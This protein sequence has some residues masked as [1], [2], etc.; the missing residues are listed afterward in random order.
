VSASQRLW[1]LS[2]REL[3]A[4]MYPHCHTA[5]VAAWLGRSVRSVYQAAE[6]RGIRKDAEYLASDTACRIQRG[7]T[8][9][10]MIPHRF[11]RGQ[12]PWNRG[13]RGVNG[14]SATRF[15]K[16]SMP[17][18]WRPV[19]SVRIERDGPIVKVSDTRKKSDW[20]PLRD[21]AWEAANGPIPAGQIVTFKPGQHTNEP[22]QITADRL[23]L[24]DRSELMRRNGVYALYGPEI[25]RLHQLRGA[26]TRQIN[27]HARQ[28]A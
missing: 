20:R 3:L 25:G 28:L 22:R 23:E 26:L 21:V 27:K 18:T 4:S 24:V 19:G 9:S 10:H 6:L 2:E 7:K 16:G 1:H 8:P 15:K 14:F 5:D 12:A 11:E 17:Q 13:R